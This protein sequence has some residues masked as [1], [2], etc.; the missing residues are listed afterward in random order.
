MPDF[1][2]LSN[3]LIDCGNFH[4]HLIDEQFECEYIYRNFLLKSS[5]KEKTEIRVKQI[6]SPYWPETCSPIKTSF[7]LINIIKNLNSNKPIIV[8]DLFG[9][10]QAGKFH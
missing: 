3:Q 7:N 10:H 6:S 2:P 8:H 1:W 4:V 5:L 9:G